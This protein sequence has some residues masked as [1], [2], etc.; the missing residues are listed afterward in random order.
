MTA[1]FARLQ[2][3][4][5]ALL[6]ELLAGVGIDWLVEMAPVT[7]PSPALTVP[8]HRVLLDSGGWCYPFRAPVGQLPFEDEALP[9]VL[10]RHLFQP[11]VGAG[12]LDEVLRCLAAGG[13]LVSVSANPWH[14][15]CWRELGSGALHLPAWPKLLFRHARHPLKLQIPRRQQWR[16]L[17]PGLSP[18]LVVVA[19][20]PPRPTR[21][22][23]L[24][25]RQ[26]AGRGQVAGVSQCEAA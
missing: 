20:K 24:K 18:V 21:V 4:E 23:K 17:M 11:G 19:R 1:G 7:S 14:P 15:Q 9:A 10:V 5:N 8:R 3:A 26:P 2:R 6:P 13:V 12:L 16:G 22:E 25:F